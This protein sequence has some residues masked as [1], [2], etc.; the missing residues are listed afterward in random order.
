MVRLRSRKAEDGAI[1]VIV[2]LLAVTM[3]GLAA[4][5]VDL[6][7][8]RDSRRQAQN[9]ADAA[10]LAAA[11]ALYAANPNEADFDDAVDAA[12]DFASSNYGTSDA[13]WDACTTDEPLAYVPA[14]VSECISFDDADDPENALVYVPIENSPVFFGGV[15]GSSGTA[16]GALAQAR[17]DFNTNP[18][19]AFCVLRDMLHWPQNGTLTVQGADV[20]INGDL[21]LNP[22]GAVDVEPLINVG[23]DLYLSG[24][25]TQNPDN[26]DGGDFIPNQPQ[27]TDPLASVRLPFATQS[28]LTTKTNP[29]TGGPGIYG[30]YRIGAGQTCTLTPGL[31]VFTGTFSAQSNVNTRLVA[32]NV[33][34]YFTCGTSAA[35]TPC[36]SGGQ[37]GG[38]LDMSGNGS[39]QISAPTPSSG[40][41]S[42]LHGFAL[43]YD[44]NNTD[45]L[46]LT[47]NANSSIVGTI[48]ARSGTFDARGNGC[49]GA[50]SSMIIVGDFR[51][52]GANA[53]FST[54]FNPADNV[55]IRRVESA[56]VR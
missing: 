56:L 11:N 49:S 18:L 52:S 12:K 43:V 10:S 15:F 30:S 44:R 50:N 8:A 39:Y 25:V 3:L 40:L 42:E 1:A 54:R 2:A 7:L 41:P 28:T 23:G 29:C 31:Y 34:M 27:I 26:A 9:T 53:C 36:A 33:T 6:G 35:P 22:Q 55:Q 46:Q 37:A 48:Y 19:C 21:R 4:I 38:D 5:V 20:R 51:F 45:T 17:I 16:V 13:D 14:G 24:T 47:G 32:N